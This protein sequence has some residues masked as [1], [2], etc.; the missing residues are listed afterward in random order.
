MRGARTTTDSRF[1]F[2][3]KSSVHPL[4]VI[5]YNNHF[6]VKNTIVQAER[7]GLRTIV[8]DNASPFEETRSFLKEIE[9]N[10]EVIRRSDNYGSVCWELPEI[11]DRL[12]KR[13]FLTDPDLQWNPQLPRDFSK[14]LDDLCTQYSAR[15]VGFAL[16]LSD[17]ELMFQDADYYGGKTIWNWEAPFWS[18]RIPHA[19][20][21]LY[22]AI[23]DTTFHLFDKTNTYGSQIRVAGDFTAKHLPW[24]R[25]TQVP[26]HDLVHMYGPHSTISKFV[27]REMARQNVRWKPCEGC[28]HLL[29][30]KKH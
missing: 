15:K 21:E 24:Y 20:L 16:D 26:A 6:Y 28:R 27:F 8:V 19:S 29:P 9:K 7:F 30:S 1:L 14:T 12:P 25:D 22:G 18:G 3:R 17:K 13:F 23:I 11:Y 10:V 2:A 4:V 5:S